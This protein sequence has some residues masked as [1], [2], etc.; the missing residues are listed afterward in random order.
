MTML[1][2]KPQVT[3][4]QQRRQRQRCERFAAPAAEAIGAADCLFS[5]LPYEER[6][7]QASSWYEACC[8]AML[9]GNYALLDEWI[10]RQAGM[11]AEERFELQ[12]LMTLLRTCRQAAMEIDG[13]NEDVFSTV[14]D[15]INEGLVAIRSKVSWDIPENINYLKPVANE[16]TPVQTCEPEPEGSESPRQ[17]E[18]R[19][20]GRNRLALP[21]RVR[22]AEAP[23]RHEE[24]THTEN[25]SLRGLYFR[26]EQR[27]EIGDSLQ[28]TYPFWTAPGAIN[29]E[30][31]ARVARVDCLEDGTLGIAAGFLEDLRKPP[32]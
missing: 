6:R 5:L 9:N 23:A 31:L 7:C 4:E 25:V 10:R 17:G 22:F 2:Q 11:A 16:I 27:Y 1:V 21:I 20:S 12:D 15:V 26:T 19:S 18:R 14:D 13:W 28:I 30:Y 29:R 24:V 32:G 8:Q 3:K